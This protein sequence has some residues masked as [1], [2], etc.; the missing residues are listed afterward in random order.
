MTTKR[1]EKRKNLIYYLP[2]YDRNSGEMLGQ[3]VDITTSGLMLVCENPVQDGE[4]FEMRMDLPSEIEGKKEIEFNARSEW[5]KK[6]V[7][8]KFFA[9]GFSFENISREQIRVIDSLIYE[10]SFQS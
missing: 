7:N 1:K 6:D 5:C 3:L 8:P 2:V 4:Y 9:A 10:F